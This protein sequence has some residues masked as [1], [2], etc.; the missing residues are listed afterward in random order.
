MRGLSAQP[1]FRPETIQIRS[2]ANT[3]PAAPATIHPLSMAWSKAEKA[4]RRAE[5]AGP[6]PKPRG[7]VPRGS[8]GAPKIWDSQQ[9]GWHED[10]RP[11]PMSTWALS[12]DSS[13]VATLTPAPA[14]VPA[15]ILEPW[16]PAAPQSA[17][18]QR[19]ERTSPSHP[20]GHMRV[21]LT[22][23]T[24]T[25]R[26]RPVRSSYLHELTPEAEQ[27][28]PWRRTWNNDRKRRHA[29]LK[30]RPDA[31]ALHLESE[32]ARKARG[33]KEAREQEEIEEEE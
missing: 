1:V 8:D 32:R 25:P 14:A 5:A 12:L 16:V 13:N 3:D 24:T 7:R 29:M 18:L 21:C 31:F 17:E 11:L 2:V 4:R 19:T 9:G 30:L 26:Q 22:A 28:E 27:L 10:T 20:P 15:T 6:Y 33:H 23:R